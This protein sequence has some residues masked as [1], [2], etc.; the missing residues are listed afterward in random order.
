[1]IA[2]RSTSLLL[3][4]GRLK[5]ICLSG[6]V[7]VP[8]VGIRAVGPEEEIEVASARHSIDDIALG[9]GAPWGF[10]EVNQLKAAGAASAFGGK[11]APA[12][13]LTS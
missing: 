7:G 3:A 8:H 11:N 13:G 9:F 10:R 2:H 5:L 12:L 1:M 4:A 6:Q